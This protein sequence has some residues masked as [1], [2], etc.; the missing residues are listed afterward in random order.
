MYDSSTVYE[1]Q[2]FWH[3]WRQK[4]QSLDEHDEEQWPF[5]R[6]PRAYAR[7][8][9]ASRTEAREQ[10]MARHVQKH[11]E[12]G[13]RPPGRDRGLSRDEI[14]RAAIA[15]A[16]AEGL[17]AISMR[18]IARELRAGAMSLY[19]HV[20]SKEEL[21]EAMREA[22]ESQVEIPDPTGDW[23]ADL[24]TFAHRQRAALL[25][26][27]WLMDILGSGPPS[28]PNDV[29]N[30]ER[31]LAL[32]S[33]ATPDLLLSV[34]LFMTLVIYVMGAVVRETQEIRGEQAEKLAEADMTEEELEAEHERVAQWFRESGRFPQILRLMEAGFDPDDPKTRDERFVFGLDTVLD[35]I[36]ARLAGS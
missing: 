3:A 35:G 27:Q 13:A 26:H 17:D 7:S 36:A 18:R 8:A 32:F 34:K 19:W 23:R 29:R 22:L 10:G 9:Q 14:V 24:W 4:E 1:R 11:R 31:M 15:L 6:P 30:F 21:L 16:D 5:S 33:Q 12:R 28:G 20:G 25:E 2:P